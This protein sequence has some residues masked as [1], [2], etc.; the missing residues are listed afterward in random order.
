MTAVPHRF[1]SAF[2]LVLAVAVVSCGS[3]R[4]WARAAGA[5]LRLSI[6]TGGTG[7]VFYP[8]GGGIAKVLSDHVPAVRVTAEVTSAS[9]DNLKFLWGGKTDLALTLADTL[10]EAYRGTGMFADVGRVPVRTLAVLYRNYTHLVAWAGSGITGVADLRGKVVSVGAPGSGTETVA[11]RVL[12]AAGLDPSRDVDRRGLGAGQ[13]VDALRDGKVDAFFWSG[14]VPTGA[15]LDLASTPNRQF[16]LVPN[17]EVLAALQAK[18]GPGLYHEAVVSAGDYPGLTVDVPVVGVA[19]ALVAD[20]GLSEPLAHDITRALFDYKAELVAIHAEARH[21]TP[22]GAVVGSPA[23]FH[24][25][26]IRFY[27]EI[28]AWPAGAR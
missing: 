2:T 14:G 15:I 3:P 8:Y 25:G 28:G 20:A 16:A 4:D 6:A 5:R 27:E 1:R 23:P 24:P 17:N 18:Y 7:G 19:I 26:A 10:D 21:L 12:E 22:A 9:V 11:L 13:S